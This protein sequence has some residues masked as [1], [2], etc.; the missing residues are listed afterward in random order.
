MDPISPHIIIMPKEGTRQSPRPSSS[1]LP[2]PLPSPRS[3]AWPQQQC[4]LEEIPEV[5]A[6]GESTF[7]K[8]VQ[9]VRYIK[10][11]TVR[12]EQPT[13]QRRQFLGRFKVASLNIDDAFVHSEAEGGTTR[14]EGGSPLRLRRTYFFQPSGIWLYR[15]LFVITLVVL[16]NL[17]MIIVRETFDQLQSSL[18]PLWL[19]VD[20][21]ADAVYVL[22]M[23]A[24]FRTSE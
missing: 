14:M 6:E 11:W 23:V 19:T 17:F 4:Q 9:T 13:D 3:N 1:S 2:T 16:Y 15:W 12:A 18:L 21:L 10:K 7:A 8:L 5:E 22:D 24:Q 20:Y